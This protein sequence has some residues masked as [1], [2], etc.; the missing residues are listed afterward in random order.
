MPREIQCQHGSTQEQGK[1][2]WTDPEVEMIL[3]GANTQLSVPGW[4][5][6][7]LKNPSAGGASGQEA[8]KPQG[9]EVSSALL[10]V[11]SVSGLR[12]AAGR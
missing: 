1:V 6:N 11:M 3:A 4:G 5:E 12:G 9:W 2:P 7:G 10:A 8:Q